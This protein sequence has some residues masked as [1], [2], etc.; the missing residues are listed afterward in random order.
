MV[1]LR[2]RRE[3]SGAHPLRNRSQGGQSERVDPAARPTRTYRG[4]SLTFRPR[5]VKEMPAFP[6]CPTITASM[7]GSSISDG[8]LHWIRTLAPGPPVASVR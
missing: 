1:H 5:L 4:A 8:P 2:R 6:L 3:H 7:I